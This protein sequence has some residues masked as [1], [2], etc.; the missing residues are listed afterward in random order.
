MPRDAGAFAVYFSSRF[1]Y[2][3]T[4]IMPPYDLATACDSFSLVSSRLE[5]H[6]LIFCGILPKIQRHTW[7][8]ACAPAV[9]TTV[10]SFIFIFHNS[11]ARSHISIHTFTHA[12]TY[13]RMHYFAPTIFVRINVHL[14]WCIMG[15][16][17]LR[18]KSWWLQEIIMTDWIKIA[19]K[20]YILHDSTDKVRLFFS[21][22]E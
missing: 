5:A 22:T 19:V 17:S 8:T 4:Q 15:T 1:I 13:I 6:C 7:P 9:L 2:S 10:N 21:F 14:S 12:Y 16:F 20:Y 18:A 11:V 3:R